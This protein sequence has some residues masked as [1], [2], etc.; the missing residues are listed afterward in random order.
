MDPAPSAPTVCE[1]TSLPL[2]TA[3]DS[4]LPEEDGTSRLTTLR[5][6]QDLAPSE[7][8]ADIY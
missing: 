8:W 5:V 7:S 1:R 4:K 2:L 6:P 3:L